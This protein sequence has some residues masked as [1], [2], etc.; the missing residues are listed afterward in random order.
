MGNYPSLNPTS[1]VDI[2]KFIELVSN[3]NP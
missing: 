1:I 3:C 2:F